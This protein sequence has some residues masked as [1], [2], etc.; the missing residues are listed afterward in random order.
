MAAA[1]ESISSGAKG[2]QRTRTRWSC[3]PW[4]GTAS[5]TACAAPGPISH[6]L[7]DRNVHVPSIIDPR[8]TVMRQY[9]LLI[10]RFLAYYC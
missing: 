8:D 6:G 10:Y 1:D 3:H 9:C 2:G 4:D 5:V 7:L